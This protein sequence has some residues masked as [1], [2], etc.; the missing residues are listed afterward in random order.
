MTIHL[1]CQGSHHPNHLN[2]SLQRHAF[3]PPVRLPP[4]HRRD[5]KYREVVFGMGR[6]LGSVDSTATDSTY[7]VIPSIISE[8]HMGGTGTV[9]NRLD[10][11]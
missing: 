1:K 8:W 2:S 11:A 9:W 6:V 5:S 4:G 7:L 3:P 10:G